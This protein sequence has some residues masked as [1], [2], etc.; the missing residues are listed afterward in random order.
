MRGYQIPFLS[1]PL[2]KQLPREIHL[3]LK[4]K[5]VV[6]EEIGN[7]FKKVAIE[8]V[9]MKKVSA[10]SLHQFE[11]SKLVHLPPLFQNGEPA[12][13]EGYPQAGQL[14]VQ[15]GSKGHIYL[16]PNGRGVGETHEILL[17]RG[18]IS[19]PVSMLWTCSSPLRFQHTIEDSNC[20][21]WENRHFDHNLS[22]RY[23][24]NWKDS[25]ECSDV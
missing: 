3:N 21:S 10:K 14:H 20:L 4:E 5:S 22:G 12:I 1:Q 23:A 7:L 9:H 24:L 11:E 18:P 13:T 6:A 16:H 17:G 8:K 25:Q 2:Q 19:I 15:I